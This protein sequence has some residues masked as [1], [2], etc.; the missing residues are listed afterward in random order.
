MGRKK[1]IQTRYSN[2]QD[3]YMDDKEDTTSKRWNYME[4]VCLYVNG[5]GHDDCME[6]NG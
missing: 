5:N 4:D 3:K 2:V 1:D 6:I